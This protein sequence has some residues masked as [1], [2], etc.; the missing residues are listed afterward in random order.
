MDIIIAAVGGFAVG[1][2]FSQAVRAWFGKEQEALH[3]KLD[4]IIAK[5]DPNATQPPA[6]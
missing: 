6:K 4:K 1:V 5:V 2:V 3:A